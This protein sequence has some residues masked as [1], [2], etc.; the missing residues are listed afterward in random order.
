MKIKIVNKIEEKVNEYQGRSGA[1]KT[2]I[3]NKMSMSP[4]RMYQLMKAENM[5]IDVLVKF[6][7]ALECKLDDLIEY[8]IIEK[9]INI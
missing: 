7:I 6:A 8:N 9:D 3:A 4:Q 2:W 5:N 1:T